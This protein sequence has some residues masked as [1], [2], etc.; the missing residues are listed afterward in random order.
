[1]HRTLLGEL[2]QPIVFTVLLLT[3]LSWLLVMVL[4]WYRADSVGELEKTLTEARGPE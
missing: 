2:R 3:C 4:V 1:M